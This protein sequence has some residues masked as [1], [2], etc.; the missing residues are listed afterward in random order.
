[1]NANNVSGGVQTRNYIN[2]Y[3][4]PERGRVLKNSGLGAT[5]GSAVGRQ[6]NLLAPGVHQGDLL[7]G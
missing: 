7:F 5:E 4:P 1:M 3:Q 2:I 6:N